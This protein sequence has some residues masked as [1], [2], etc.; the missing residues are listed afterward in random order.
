MTD[1]LICAMPSL[2]LDRS[3]SAPAL[4]RSAVET[5]GYTARTVDFNLAWFWK[6]CQGNMERFNELGCVFRNSEVAS[7][8]SIKAA[9]QWLDQTLNY[10]EQINP[11]ILG[12][13]VFSI[14]QH[15]SVWRL[16]T[17][18]RQRF[19]DMKIVLGGLGLN[20]GCSSLST[21]PGFRKIDLVKPFHQYMKI[22]RAHV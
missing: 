11:R 21:E 7:T 8:Q 4:L 5:A 12:L 17:A 15:R 6:Q 2:F 1:I 14:Q 13:S 16:A 9:E 18:A 22:G 19:P 10:I 3:P 20:V